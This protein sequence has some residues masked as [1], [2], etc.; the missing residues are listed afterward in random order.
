[1]QQLEIPTYTCIG[2]GG[3]SSGGM[4]GWNIIG[5]DDEYYNVDVTW[6]DSD[7]TIYDYFNKSDSDFNDLHSRM[8]LSVYLP[9]CNG[10]TYS[11]LEKNSLSDFGLSASD[12]I[13][14]MDDYYS[15]CSQKVSEAIAENP[16]E[17]FEFQVV[18]SEDIYSEWKSSYNSGEYYSGFLTDIAMSSDSILAVIYCEDAQLSE[19]CYLINVTGIVK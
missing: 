8:W 13:Y 1:M 12:V 11:G 3:G 14:S 6:D 18:I 10:T 17:E 5:L 16:G 15:I 9:A 2:W 19:G 4:H 7:P